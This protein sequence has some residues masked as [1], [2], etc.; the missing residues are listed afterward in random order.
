MSWENLAGGQ[1]ASHHS[2]EAYRRKVEEY[3]ESTGEFQSVGDSHSGTSDIRLVRPVHKEKKVFRVETKNSKLSITNPD[4]L[5]ELARQFI[6]QNTG[7]EDFEFRV[8]AED[9]A[10][11]S[12]WRNVFDDPIRKHDEVEKFWTDLKEKH[13]LND[14]ET[15][16]FEQLDFDDF[17]EFLEIV[18]IKKVPYGRLSELIDDHDAR[19]DWKKKYE[20][21]VQD[22]EP[23]KER[24]PLIPNFVKITKLPQHRWEIPSTTSDHNTIYESTPRYTPLW[25][26]ANTVYSLLN[27]ECLPDT[28][29]K[30]LSIDDATKT[31]FET[32]L[33]E[34]DSEQQERIRKA[35]LN[36]Q[37]VWRGHHLNDQSTVVRHN[38]VHKLIMKR[39][40]TVQQTLEFEDAEDIE[41][42]QKV[43]KYT[44]TKDFSTAIAHRFGNPVVRSYGGDYYAFINTGWLF[45]RNGNG[46]QVITGDEAS[47]LHHKL[48]KNNLERTPNIRGQ[49]RQWMTYLRIGV[50]STS[51]PKP[52]ELEG[53]DQSQIMEFD[54]PSGLEM[55]VRPPETTDER[56]LLMEGGTIESN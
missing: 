39:K 41:R 36:R 4:F 14:D 22:N 7:S 20:F 32:P 18:H 28:L 49:I 16:A 8:Y 35:L 10:N 25:L 12:K 52:A 15:A 34:V 2:G 29:S 47:A 1:E 44:A 27:P 24:K 3:L 55:D 56:D 19:E 9:Y 21:Y 54:R 50:E 6:D 30:H 37:L 51:V 23:V 42:T 46:D 48:S 13:N 31:G 11:Q 53:L 43:K 26:E 40:Q 5:T 33:D 45:T 38:G 17:W